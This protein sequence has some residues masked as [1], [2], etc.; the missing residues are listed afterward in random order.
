MKTTPTVTRK[1]RFTVTGEAYPLIISDVSYGVDKINLDDDENPYAAEIRMFMNTEKIDGRW[2]M[3][4]DDK[5]DLAKL[6]ERVADGFIKKIKN[7]TKNIYQCDL[8]VEKPQ[9]SYGLL[10]FDYAGSCGSYA[11]PDGFY[12]SFV[13][14]LSEKLEQCVTDR[15]AGF[16]TG[17]MSFKNSSGSVNISV[18]GRSVDIEASAYESDERHEMLDSIC[19]EVWGRGLHEM[20]ESIEFKRCQQEWGAE[21]IDVVVDYLIDVICESGE[22]DQ[23][24]P[25]HRR[26]NGPY[27]KAMPKLVLR[28]AASAALS[29]MSASDRKFKALCDR[30]KGIVMDEDETQEQVAA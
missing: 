26:L 28:M 25:M 4:A 16:D 17:W 30:I 7:K 1:C 10:P 9:K 19:L 22:P 13:E 2:V 23:S 27:S 29:A 3:C 11:D 14:I 18:R 8:E 20:E 12:Q 15:S 5:W 21:S 24:Y 6:E